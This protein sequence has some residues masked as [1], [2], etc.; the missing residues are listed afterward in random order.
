VS[1]G[2]DLRQGRRPER[3]CFAR[4]SSFHLNPALEAAEISAPKDRTFLAS[5]QESVRIQDELSGDARVEIAVA[6]R[7][8]GKRDHRSIHYLSDGKAVMKDRLHQLSVVLKNRCLASKKTG[9]ISPNR[10]RIAS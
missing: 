9:E 2:R 10:G 4:T 5:L 6:L 1:Y 8:V 7:S 3:T